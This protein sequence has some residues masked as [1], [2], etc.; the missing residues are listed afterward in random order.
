MKP[1]VGELIGQDTDGWFSLVNT[2]SSNVDMKIANRKGELILEA[3][4]EPLSV[5]ASTL[6]E[7]YPHD[8]L[9]YSWKTLMKNHT[10]DSIC[11]CS[12]DEVTAEMK[13]RFDK[14]RQAAEKA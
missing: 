4:A 7:E 13:T 12:C 5:M 10:H 9:L 2:S 8:M 3:V 1:V 14:S 11:G 6:G